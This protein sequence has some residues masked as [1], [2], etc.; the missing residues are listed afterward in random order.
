MLSKSKSKSKKPRELPRELFAQENLTKL[1]S[2]TDS[3]S[4]LKADEAEKVGCSV[5]NGHCVTHKLLFHP[6]CSIAKV[7]LTRGSSF[8]PHVH[9]EGEGVIM[10][11]GRLE[12][13]V[14]DEI[15]T[16]KPG[17]FLLI[18][19]GSIHHAKAVSD[20]EFVAITVPSNEGFPQ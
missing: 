3:L 1:K 8:P 13:V 17:D 10:L 20:C 6:Y 18:Y 16:M 14:E 7:S 5:D 19:P 4:N 11:A 12:F 15:T 9:K 2:L